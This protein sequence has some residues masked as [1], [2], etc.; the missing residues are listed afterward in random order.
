MPPAEDLV[1]DRGDGKQVPP[2]TRR[3]SAGSPN[4]RSPI[5]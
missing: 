1:E 5:A 3:S 4:T 2:G